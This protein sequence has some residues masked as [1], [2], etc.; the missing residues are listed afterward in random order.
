MSDF[1]DP[2]FKKDFSLLHTTLPNFLFDMNISSKL[3][4]DETS[5]TIDHSSIHV[6]NKELQS[7][8][9][10]EN[11]ETNSAWSQQIFLLQC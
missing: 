1:I 2:S 3:R 4:N 5:E 8:S 10:N 6:V 7:P 9:D 11:F